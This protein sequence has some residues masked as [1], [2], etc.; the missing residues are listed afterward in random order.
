MYPLYFSNF[1]LVIFSFSASFVLSFEI[2]APPFV[3]SAAYS[4]IQ[5]IPM[6]VKCQHNRRRFVHKLR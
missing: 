1:Q 5:H 3:V 6:A 4:R 2:S